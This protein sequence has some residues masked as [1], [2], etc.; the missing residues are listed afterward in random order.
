MRKNEI[1]SEPGAQDRQERSTAPS[2]RQFLQ[3]AAIGAVAVAVP[4]AG[5]AETHQADAFLKPEDPME[6]ALKRY[7]S[8]L[9][10]LKRIG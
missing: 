10:N 8:E 7:G 5:I 2:R 6:K 9:G 4:V 1:P 3:A